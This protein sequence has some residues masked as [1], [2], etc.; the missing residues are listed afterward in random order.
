[1]PV[2]SGK[3]AELAGVSRG[4]VDRALHNRGGVNPEVEKRI[5]R[6]AE[7]LGYKPDRA[8]KAL[9]SRKNPPKIGVLLN[10]LGNPFFDEVKRG[11]AAA[12]S[13]LA[14]FRLKIMLKELKGYRVEDQL[15]S[16]EEFAAA[17][18]K[19]IVIMPLNDPRVAE[20]MN[21]LSEKGIG[22]VTVNTDIGGTKR[23]AYVG[24]DYIKSGRTAAGLAEL[25][26]PGET[27][28]LIIT[29]SV[30]NMGHNERIS[31]FIET[32]EGRSGL[33]LTDIAENQDDE[34]TA[35][36]VA[37]QKL[38]EHP[39]INMIYMVS[40]GVSGAARAVSERSGKIHILCFDSTPQVVS[41]VKDK[42]IT[43]TICQE[44]FKQGY[45]SVQILFDAVVNGILPENE[46][47][48]TD[49]QI[50]IRQNI[51]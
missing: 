11:I 38:R 9:S 15:S 29:G 48:Y 30:K 21:E 41:L 40:A 42:I 4:T 23:I 31:G 44:P 25:I 8:G 27:N 26:Q 22:F 49:C 45:R 13:E 34:E 50:K 19:G 16:L 10:S 7:Q 33:H 43:A 32:A 3:I 2:T 35:Y 47:Q 20:K 17:G 24:C 14:D 1:M 36:R 12:G 46:L 51:E 39:E 28:L 6:L 5:K 37:A 18:V